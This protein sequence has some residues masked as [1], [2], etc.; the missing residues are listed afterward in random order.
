MNIDGGGRRRLANNLEDSLP[1]WA[2]DQVS[3]VF[4]SKRVGPHRISQVFSNT[5][6][7]GER[8]LGEGD[9]PDWSPDG[10]HIVAKGS[11]SGTGLIIMDS[12]GGGRRQLTSNLN[13]SSPDWS[14]TGNKIVFMRQTGINWD[15]WVINSDGTGET[16]L[17]SDGAIDGL[18]AWSP[19]GTSVA[20]LSNHGGTWA[21]WVMNANGSNQRKLFNTGCSNY[22]TGGF[23]GEYIGR[24]NWQPRDWYDEQISWSR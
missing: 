13:D 3:T 11:V 14:P 12:S 18:P 24:D 2:A 10:N 8:Q 22:A 21:I 17:T 5:P 6:S 7:G 9:M 16:K 4:G 15:I 19:D 23:D 1:R 20:F